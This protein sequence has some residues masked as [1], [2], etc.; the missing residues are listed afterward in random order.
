MNT[1]L[2]RV[3]GLCCLAAMLAVLAVVARMATVSAFNV[4]PDEKD[5]VSAGKYY[6]EYWDQPKVGDPRAE[7]AYSNYGI[8]YL[9][10]M[11]AVY[12]FAGKFARLILPLAGS[13]FMALRFFNVTLLGVL[14]LLF[15]RL[16]WEFRPA[17]LPLFISPQIWYIFSYFNGDALPLFCCFLVVYLL[18]RM[19]DAGRDMSGTGGGSR[20][21]TLR[22]LGMGA[23]LGVIAVSKQNYF[24]FLAFFAGFTAL[25]AWFSRRGTLPWRQVFLVVGLMVLI[26]GARWGSSAWAERQ[27]APDAVS[28]MAEQVAAEDKKPS[29]IVA[30]QAY[31]GMR[32]REHGV[33][34]Q[35]M[36]TGEWKWHV[37]AQRTSFG[38]YEYSR[39]E[40]LPLVY[41]RYMLYLT[42]ALMVI[43]L[44]PIALE[45]REGR[46]MA[47]LWLGCAL[48]TVFQSFWHSWTNDFQAQGRYFFPILGMTGCLLARFHRQ[49][50]A[51]RPAL[52]TVVLVM[53]GMSLWSFIG[54]GLARIPR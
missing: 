26:F 44:A 18:A 37:F 14:L 7:G 1:A 3:L 2:R 43:I 50:A 21:A 8:S 22:F 17:F 52:W 49:V 13:D 30:G 41:Y 40:T 39:I 5:H 47:A 34:W 48:L 23:A 51:I 4:H 6:M 12:F 33:T 32:M 45:G 15:W 35:E 36:F 25:V 31:W 42:C 24:I 28:R 46:A 11:D 27:Q 10:Q 9:H 54:T 29:K 19:L 16:P 53:W 38:L 20:R